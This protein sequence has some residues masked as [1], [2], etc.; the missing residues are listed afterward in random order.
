LFERS[1]EAE[2]VL[3]SKL[4]QLVGLRVKLDP[5]AILS[6]GRPLDD[7][8][9]VTNVGASAVEIRNERNGVM[10]TLGHDAIYSFFEDE[11]RST[12][13]ARYGTLQLH[14]QV[15]VLPDSSTVVKPLPPPK[16]AGTAFPFERFNPLVVRDNFQRERYFSWSRHCPVH[17]CSEERPQQ[18]MAFYE[19]LCHVL[20]VETA[21]E[22]EFSLVSDLRGEQVFELS[23][24][25][26][27]RWML[28][29][30]AGGKAGDAVLVLTEKPASFHNGDEILGK[31]RPC[32]CGHG[33]ALLRGTRAEIV[34]LMAKTRLRLHCMMCDGSFELTIEEKA[35][36]KSEL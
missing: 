16:A 4:P 17:L 19:E 27:A 5:P 30:G 11:T 9:L 14:S 13:T 8:W 6:N 12:S 18:L 23:P 22:P 34:Q 1:Y 3:K 32:P 33:T 2:S 7:D 26:R 25:Y 36:L 31:Q 28:L 20:R 10:S 24:D 29:G 15:T 35:A 21:R